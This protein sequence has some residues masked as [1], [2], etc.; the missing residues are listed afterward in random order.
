MD[1][2]GMKETDNKFLGVVANFH[3]KRHNSWSQPT[4][5]LLYV[6]VEEREKGE[7]CGEGE[8]EIL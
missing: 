3:L 6:S 7:E 1:A 4:L 8:K 2:K 5:N